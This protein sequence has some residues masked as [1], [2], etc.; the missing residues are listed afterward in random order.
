MSRAVSVALE[1][2]S[3]MWREGLV[4]LRDR[5]DWLESGKNQR[6]G[7]GSM[8]TSGASGSVPGSGSFRGGSW[9]SRDWGSQFM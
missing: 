5:I 3:K 8:W 1:Q 4:G 7:Q 6:Y 2:E 9:D